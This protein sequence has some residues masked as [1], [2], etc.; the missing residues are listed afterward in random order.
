[1]ADKLRS[2]ELLLVLCAIGVILA[3]VVLF[4]ALPVTA[5][6]F[7]L[8]LG[9]V[10]LISLLDYQRGFFIFLFFRPL[11]D[12]TTNQKLFSFGELE[13]NFL[14]LYGVS[15]LVF[16]IFVFSFNFS[17]LKNKRLLGFFSL[18]ILWSLFSFSYS[19]DLGASAKELLRYSSI[20]FS[21]I[22]GGLLIKKSEELTTMIK[23]II[24]SA[25]IPSLVALAQFFT[26]T[27]LI[28]G[29]ANRLL[30]TMAHPNMLAFYLLLP[31]TLAIFI[32]LNVKRTRL[33][34]YIYLLLAL[35]YI[36]ILIFTYTRGA[37]LAL[38]GVFLLIG[39]LKFRRFLLLAGA[40]F[41]FFYLVALPFQTRFNTI[42]Q[43]D[44]YGSISWRLGLYR[45]SL[46]YV[47]ANPV[48]G[49]GLGLAETVI[50]SNRDFRLGAA[51]PH[52]DYL[53]IALDGGV[54]GL[55]FYLL[56][57]TVLLLE[58]YR[59]Y[60]AE[61]RPR[62]KMLSVFILALALSLYALSLGDNILNDTSLQ[63][64]FWALIGAMLVVGTRKKPADLP[65]A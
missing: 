19:F 39:L 3:T 44:P 14:A 45:D 16:A 31:I 15:L 53:R 21:F 20:L 54:I 17:N 28:E 35:F 52:N 62:L 30:G 56:L 59:L 40:T 4:S 13:V 49:Y 63:W 43:A 1:M 37:Y 2:R 34:A 64:Q 65:Q 9:L 23:V 6:I 33:E 27:G 8:A 47:K 7:L 38:I 36:F 57:I 50:A 10:F 26:G 60:R 42:F 48:S 32:F 29:G 11:I 41:I 18:F 12:F 46:T 51:Q 55:G 24:F 22:L 5:K 61:N 58:L 25:L